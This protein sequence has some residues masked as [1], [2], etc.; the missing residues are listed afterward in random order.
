MSLT[1][2]PLKHRFGAMYS[3]YL[4]KTNIQ[5]IYI[6]ILWMLSPDRQSQTFRK[7]IH[8]FNLHPHSRTY[9]CLVKRTSGGSD[10]VCEPAQFVATYRR[11]QEVR[12][13]ALGVWEQQHSE[14]LGPL[15]FACIGWAHQLH[16]TTHCLH[17]TLP[18]WSRHAPRALL[19]GPSTTTA[20]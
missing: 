16:R 6:Y 2:S 1:R 20:R 10:E 5:Y 18:S 14:G 8:T 12:F 13:S 17:S 3:K 7:N 9:S 11:V 19:S 4:L 15:Q